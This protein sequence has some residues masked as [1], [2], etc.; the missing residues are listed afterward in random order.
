MPGA[1]L[2][3]QFHVL[4]SALVMEVSGWLLAEFE[5]LGSDQLEGLERN[6]VSG[7]ASVFL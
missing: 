3:S 7:P 5:S 6:A 2:Q 4:G 1:N